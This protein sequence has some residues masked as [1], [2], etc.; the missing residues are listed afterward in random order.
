MTPLSLKC[1]ETQDM[2]TLNPTTSN[3]TSKIYETAERIFL[4]FKLTVK[5]R[6]KLAND[7]FYHSNRSN[8]C[9][10]SNNLN[11]YQ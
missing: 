6:H 2:N 5:C 8:L 4:I 7:Y 11:N 1:K 3:K 10:N 9:N